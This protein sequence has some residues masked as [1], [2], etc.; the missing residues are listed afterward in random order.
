[1][2]PCLS[3][4]IMRNQINDYLKFNRTFSR[5]QYGSKKR[6]TIDTIKYATEFIRKNQMKT[7]LEQR[8]SLI[9]LSILTQLTMKC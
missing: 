3:K 5:H 2:T 9:S 7:N 4:V 6:S 8:R 1:M